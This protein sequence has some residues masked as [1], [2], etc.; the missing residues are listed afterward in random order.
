MDK[1]KQLEELLDNMTQ[2]DIE[3]LCAFLMEACNAL[4]TYD[5][6]ANFLGKSKGALTA[7]I[8]RSVVKPV[9]RRKMLRYSDVMKIKKKLV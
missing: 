7:K 6:A 3:N 5:Q 8:S 1:R 4:M 9:P 2:D